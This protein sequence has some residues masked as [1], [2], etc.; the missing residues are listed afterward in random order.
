MERGCCD[1]WGL[2]LVPCR[3]RCEPE[4]DIVYQSQITNNPTSTSTLVGEPTLTGVGAVVTAAAVTVVGHGIQPSQ[5]SELNLDARCPSGD[6][7]PH[8]SSSGATIA[9]GHGDRLWHLHR[10]SADQGAPLCFV[11]QD[12]NRRGG[13]EWGSD[14]V[15]LLNCIVANVLDG[16]RY[17]CTQGMHGGCAQ[18]T[19]RGTLTTIWKR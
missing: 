17:V 5:S 15:A 4:R 8:A 11:S 9:D 7:S 10:H 16:E 13:R 6:R 18:L 2:L 14:S 12:S 1:R 19:A 3:R